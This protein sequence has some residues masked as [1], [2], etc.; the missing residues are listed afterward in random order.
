MTDLRK[1]RPKPKVEKKAAPIKRITKQIIEMRRD[2]AHRRRTGE[3][4]SNDIRE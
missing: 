3:L 4:L 1:D 2:E